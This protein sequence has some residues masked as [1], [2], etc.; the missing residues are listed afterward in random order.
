[1]SKKK[2]KTQSVTPLEAVAAVASIVGAIATVL[3]WLG[4]KP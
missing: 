1:M 2:K 4:I 3:G